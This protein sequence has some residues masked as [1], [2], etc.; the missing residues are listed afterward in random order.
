MKLFRKT[1]SFAQRIQSLMSLVICKLTFKRMGGGNRVFGSITC[2]NPRNIEIGNNCSINHNCYINA[3]NPVHIGDDVT[4]A[5][6]SSIISTGM[7]VESWISGKK[8]HITDKRGIYIGDH[9][10]VGAG[11]IILGGVQ[12]TGKY[13]VIGAGS[14]VTKDISESYCVVCGCPAKVIKRLDQPS[15]DAPPINP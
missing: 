7:D 11:S 15:Q 1:L 3:F 9:V 10:V 8:R 2:I 5:A 12:I 6:N 13:V 14:I 4:L